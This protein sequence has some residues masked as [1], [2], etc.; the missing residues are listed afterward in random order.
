MISKLL[1]RLSQNK[2]LKFVIFKNISCF[3]F[4]VGKFGD[5]PITKPLHSA[6]HY[7]KW[8]SVQ[9]GIPDFS[10]QQKVYLDGY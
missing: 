5:F 8:P 4:P 3:A 10:G 9:Y 1:L 6:L 2:Y 7:F